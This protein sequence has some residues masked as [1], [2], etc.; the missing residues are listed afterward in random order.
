[1]L[2]A[3]ETDLPA[4][5]SAEEILAHPQFRTARNA[6]VQAMLAL[7]EHDPFLNR[8]LLEIGR[9]VLFV[10]IMCLQA[11][12]DESD[13]A[14]WLTLRLVK[15]AMSAFIVASPRR[16]ADLVSRLIATGYLEQLP[17]P[18]DRRLRILR[19]TRRMILQD[20]DWLISH[21]VPLQVLFPEPGYG[22]IMQRDP[23]F[24]RLQRFAAASLFPMGARLMARHPIMMGFM[25][26]EAGIMI[27]IKLIQLAEPNGNATRAISYSDIGTR[28]GLSRTSVRMLL[29]ESEQLGL[30][31]LS[32]EKGPSV[33]LTPLLIEAFDKFI[34]DG[35]AGHDLIYN[36]AH[37]AAASR[38]AYAGLMQKIPLLV[39]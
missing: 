5:H 14:T 35:M 25:T 15:K 38:A 22:R 12:Y 39:S 24:Q 34:A 23:E 17:S 3:D 4:H 1:M 29:Q 28:F 11:R 20:Q 9:N 30:V 33:E 31:H 21:Y 8:L 2:E 16:I 19:P 10:V 13:P 32:R 26:R 7:Y 36:L 37:H 18:G 6:L 27:L